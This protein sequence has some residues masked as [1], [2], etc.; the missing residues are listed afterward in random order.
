M[1]QKYKNIP[2]KPEVYE[3]VQLVAEAN[4]FGE[5]GL[6]AQVAQWVARELPECA[7]KKTPVSI[8]TFPRH[9]LTAEYLLTPAWYCAVCK[10]VYARVSE[11]DLLASQVQ[12]I[13]E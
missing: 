11:T 3:R 9:E 2:V 12:E 10:R 4:G 5:R 1:A 6:G 8:E 13:H 7:H